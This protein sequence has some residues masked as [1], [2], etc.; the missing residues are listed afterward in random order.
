[1]NGR[2]VQGG[3]FRTVTPALGGTVKWGTTEGDKTKETKH[4]GDTGEGGGGGMDPCILGVCVT[5]P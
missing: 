3:F 2:R 5:I 1:M 4:T